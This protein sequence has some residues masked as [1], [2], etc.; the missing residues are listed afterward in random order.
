MHGKHTGTQGDTV[1][2]QFDLQ[3]QFCQEAG[4]VRGLTSP[5][6]NTN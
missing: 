6:T 2:D 4:D 1:S 5:E 3:E